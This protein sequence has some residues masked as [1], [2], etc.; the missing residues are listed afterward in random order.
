M[1]TVKKIQLEILTINS[2]VVEVKNNF[3][4]LICRQ[5]NYQGKTQ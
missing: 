5:K 1:E 3:K 4:G 2:I